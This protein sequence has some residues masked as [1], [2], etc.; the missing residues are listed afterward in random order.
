M[1]LS[2]YSSAPRWAFGDSSELADRLLELVLAGTK[3][4]TCSALEGYRIDDEP[5]PRVGQLDIILDG[6]GQP[7]C[8]IRNVAVD[9][10]AFRD[11]DEA[12]ARQEGEGDL[13]LEYWRREHQAFFEREYGFSPDML[14]VFEHFEVIEEFDLPPRNDDKLI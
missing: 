6:L 5:L 7:R 2:D 1:P 13:S 3:T 8:V 9:T 12:L 14:L 11:V 10:I 4:A